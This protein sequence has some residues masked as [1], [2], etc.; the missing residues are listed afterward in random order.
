MAT[1]TVSAK[2]RVTL[3]KELLQH[4]G[5]EP[6]GKIEI[7]LLPLGQASLRPV[8]MTGKMEDFLGC[9]AGKTSVVLTIDEIN[10]AAARGWAGKL[11]S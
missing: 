1:L 7:D 2:G 11:K 3:P 10:D 5:I 6:G 8:Q 9:L 4:L